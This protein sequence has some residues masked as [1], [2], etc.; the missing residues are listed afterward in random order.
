L[1]AWTAFLA[2]DSFGVAN[3][4]V[5]EVVIFNPNTSFPHVTSDVKAR[6]VAWA[7]SLL[8][9]AIATSMNFLPPRSYAWVFRAG[10]IVIIID[11]LL[12]FIWLPIGVSK[13][14]GFQ[15]AEFVFTS[16]Y[17]GGDTAPG[18]NWVLSVSNKPL[19]P[20]SCALVSAGQ[21]RVSG[22]GSPPEISC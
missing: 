22:L 15:T 1:V 17:N 13:T 12:N 20:L 18:L 10:V 21:L 4:L 8:F 19:Y 11:M 7:F 6:A 16:T 2:A 3:Y 5:S 14:Y 9:L